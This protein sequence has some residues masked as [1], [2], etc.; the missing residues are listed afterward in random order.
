MLHRHPFLSLVTGAYLVFVAWLTLT[1]Q[2][3]HAGTT[4]LALRVL[5]ALHRRGYA[6][7]IGYAELEFGANIAMFVPIGVFLL[8]L[9]GAGGWWLAIAVS[10][11]MTAGI[12]SLQTQIPGRVPDDRDLLANGL[13]AV[14]GVALA[15]VLTAPAT[16]RRRRA[17]ARRQEAARRA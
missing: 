2:S 17:K 8:L 5:D 6:E 9:F 7:P 1:P 10:F 12:E 4:D 14:I 11:A 3:N 15:L 13:G 16:I